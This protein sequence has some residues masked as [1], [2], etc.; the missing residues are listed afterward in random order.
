MKAREGVPARGPCSIGQLRMRLQHPAGLYLGCQIRGPLADSRY[1]LPPRARKTRSRRGAY[2]AAGRRHRLKALRPAPPPRSH[3]KHR[4][5]A[6]SPS[7]DPPPPASHGPTS[8]DANV[9]YREGTGSRRVRALPAQARARREYSARGVLDR[10]PSPPSYTIP[11]TARLHASSRARLP[12]RFSPSI[13]FLG[14][15]NQSPEWDAFLVQDRTTLGNVV[16][17]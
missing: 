15:T 5:F 10:L 2:R 8:R 1:S 16:I 9:R 7:I 12:C 6:P 17:G 4:S 3:A 11:K 13:G 14:Q